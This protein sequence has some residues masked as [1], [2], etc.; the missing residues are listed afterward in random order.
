MQLDKFQVLEVANPNLASYSP[1]QVLP[2]S[3]AREALDQLQSADFDPEVAVLAET[4]ERLPELVPAP[5]ADLQFVRGGYTVTASSPDWSLIVLPVQFSHCY[6]LDGAS[7]QNARLLRVNLVQ[8]G[9]L[10][11]GD[12]ALNVELRRWPFASPECQRQDY[13]DATRLRITDVQRLVPI[14]KQTGTLP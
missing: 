6:V 8:T 2:V 9:L 3:T 11:H 12:V 10:V 7:A 1:T 5:P 13:L 4:G 14:P